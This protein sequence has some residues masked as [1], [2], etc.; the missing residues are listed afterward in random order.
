MSHK[1][2][3]Q[4]LQQKV[5][6][7]EK[8]AYER[9]RA[10]NALLEST[11]RLQVAY[12]QAIVYAKELRDE[13]TEH[14]RADEA[15]QEASHLLDKR[16]E[17]RTAEL[18][19]AVALL[20]REV[21]ERRRVEEAL[22][23][24]EV[25]LK[26]VLD[27]IQA[28]IVVVDPKTHAVVGVNAAAGKMFG[29]PREQILGRLCQECFCTAGEGQCPVTDLGQGLENAEQELVTADGRRVPILKTV[30]SV[31]LNNR[32]HLLESFLDITKRK[33]AEEALWESEKRVYTHEKHVE[34]LKFANDVALK[35]MHELRN[36]LAAVGG[37]S[38]L[39][40]S[41]DYPEDKLREYAK[42]IMEQA[43][44]LDKAV[45]DV[46]VHLKAGAEEL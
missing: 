28:G 3:Y 9:Q 14:K 1:P 22:R 38:K 41:K 31:T 29:A 26:T 39:I 37:F 46:L 33:Q 34:I 44:R 25:R 30:V 12:D 10:D 8:E 45:N 32:E 16:V 36:P 15:L 23:E 2:T 21:A 7:L 19:G 13:I 27:T 35:L 24:S 6:A 40:S 5:S 17:G 43:K 18:S 42:I 20:E 4:E 11:R